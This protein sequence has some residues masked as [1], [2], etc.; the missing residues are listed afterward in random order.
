M[1]YMQCVI[2]WSGGNTAFVI[3]PQ[4]VLCE[5]GLFFG[6]HTRQDTTAQARKGIGTGHCE[7]GLEP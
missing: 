4:H 2:S 5:V 3:T 7:R 1:L 6:L